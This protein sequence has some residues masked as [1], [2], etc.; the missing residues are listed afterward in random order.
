M[1]ESLAPHLKDVTRFNRL[2]R[3]EPGNEEYIRLQAEMLVS[4]SKELLIGWCN[5]DWTEIRDGLAD[6]VVVCQGGRFLANSNPEFRTSTT[7]TSVVKLHKACA[8]IEETGIPLHEDL[9]AV[10]AS[11]LSKF[12]TSEEEAIATI[13]K[14]Q[15]LCVPCES[16]ATGDDEYRFG[17]YAMESVTGKDV[18]GRKKVGEQWEDTTEWVPLVCFGRTAENVGKYLVKGSKIRAT[19]RFS[20]SSWE[21]DGERRYKCWEDQATIKEIIP[22]KT[23][24]KRKITSS[25][26]QAI[27]QITSL[28]VP[29]HLAGGTKLV[30]DFQ[31]FWS[32][33]GVD[34][35]DIKGIETPEFKI[36]KPGYT[37]NGDILWE[38]SYA[39]DGFPTVQDVENQ[40]KADPDNDWRIY[41]HAPLYEAEYQ[42]QGDGVWVLVMRGMEDN[43]VHSIVVDPPYGLSK[44]PDI[45]EVMR[46]WLNGD[47]YEHGASGFMG[48]SWDSFVPGPE[49]WREALRVLKPGG[50]ALVF[51]GT[52]TQ[53]LMTVALRFAGFEVR[54]S[55]RYY[56]DG[57]IY[58]DHYPSSWTFGQGFP[59]S[60]NVSKA[61]DKK[62]GADRKVA[63]PNKWASKR[64]SDRSD[65]VN[66]Y[67]VRTVTPITVPASPEAQQWDGY[68]TALKPAYE[69]IILVRKPLDGTV[70]ANVLKHGT[71]AINI[72]GCR[73]EG[74]PEP[75]RFNPDKHAHEGWRMNHTGRQCADS[76]TSKQGRFPANLI[77]DG[78]DAV[79][80]LFPD[81]QS[82]GYPKAGGRRS[83]QSTYGKPNSRGEQRFTSSKGSAAR[84][85]YCA[86]TSKADR[87]EGLDFKDYQQATRRDD[88]QKKGMN[89]SKTRPDG[90]ERKDVQPRKNNHPTVKPTSL[91]R[92]LVRLITPPGGTVLDPFA[93]SGSTGKAAILEGFDCILIE[94]DAGFC[95]IIRGRCAW[96]E[97]QMQQEWADDEQLSIPFA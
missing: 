39:E 41:F 71:G 90:S 58:D 34:M 70:A 43:S 96:A 18:S 62:L 20:T 2:M 57:E 3:R 40:A 54:D 19:G 73:V 25:Q 56:H 4:E 33:G 60:Q 68:G 11:N 63:G 69:P 65:A 50:H 35:I 14:Y 83:H 55:L 76:A 37:K 61:L 31:V 26:R 12:P 95:E 27:K 92:W 22:V 72:D 36:K 87:D 94:Q 88:G 74:A 78:S 42:R 9:A 5:Q 48:K 89:T 86:K 6:V 47:S 46:H 44:E 15:Q 49:Y 16:I 52:R 79:V 91:M 80:A 8:E 81:S 51:A 84:F 13:T 85:F 59:K 66:C 10:N 38:E 64:T 82:G 30:V 97:Q 67:G 77:H 23:I 93:G 53:D 75:T 17:I 1:R 29:I 7:H 24:I 45:A 28:Q 32:D 21:K